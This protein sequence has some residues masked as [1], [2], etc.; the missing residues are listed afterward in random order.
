MLTGH[1][2]GAI[3]LPGSKL[4]IDCDFS[5]QADGSWLGDVSIPAQNAKD[6]PLTGIAFKGGEVTFAISGIP[7]EPVFKG[8]LSTDG[9]AIAGE[10]VQGGNSFAFRLQRAGSAVE[11]ARVA[12][13]AFD[14]A[15]AKGLKD[16]NVPGVAVAIVVD[17]EVVLAK[18]YG[19]RDLEQKIPMDADTI[20]AIGSSSK[21][22]TTFAMGTLV[23]QGK[24][25]WDVPVRRYIPWFTLTDA[26]TSERITP[27]D[28]VTHRSGLPRHDLVWY[29]NYTASREEFV[30]R[31]AYLQP[32]ADLREKFQYNNLMFLTAGFLVETLTG[33]PWE[34]SIRG[35]VLE[36]LG[37]SRTNFSVLDSQK[38]R[39]FAFPYRE[40]K[41]KLERMPFRDI[42]N[43]GPAGAINSTV[44]E[45]SRWLLVH[46]NGGEL[47]GR[48]IIQ[49][50]T[51]QDMHLSH[52]PT[53]Q[54]PEIPELSPASYG[55]GWFVDSYRGHG[56]VHHGG[57]ID[58][59][60]AMISMF[61][62]DRLGFVVLSNLNGTALPELLIR[63]ATDLIFGLEP[64]DWLGEAAARKAKGMDL[65]RQAEQKK[66]SRRVAK[67]KPA[68]DLEAYAGEYHHPGYGDLRVTLQNGRLAFTYNGIITP[69]EHWH[70]ETFNGLKTADP[71]FEDFKLLSRTDADGRVYALEAQMEPTL[72]AIVF[73]KRPSAR[74]FDPAFL[75]KFTGRYSML[76]QV[77][78][79]SLKG[80]SL[81]LVIPGQPEYDLVPGL[82]E[83]FTLKQAQVVSFRF[84]ADAKGEIVALEAIQPNGIFEAKRINEN[85][86]KE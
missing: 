54:T 1:W 78:T 3:E 52:M 62:D 81:K 47:N 64:K 58:G 30:R 83:E 51:L 77:L 69:L 7:G 10:F 79:V 63:Q 24:L 42:T 32:T 15:V 26:G 5:I 65:A 18:G 19:Y 14:E 75:K 61:P 12:L 66:L 34:D 68:H 45:M 16:L 85:Q 31:L 50:Q 21:A 40:E 11:K 41:S 8:S 6:L 44:G 82:D 23:D 72:E 57:N 13:A 73:K 39:N 9:A 56:R 53:G 36:P 37:M 35:L 70:Y 17:N 27:R 22:F 67:T 76:D 84:K 2:A 28:L 48:P 55:M 4:E 46:L 25:E 29:N 71:T 38:D 80:S 20:L 74:L 33:K 59:F 86:G 49:P 43:I 60:S